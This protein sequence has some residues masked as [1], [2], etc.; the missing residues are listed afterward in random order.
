GDRFRRGPP[1][2]PH[3]PRRGGGVPLHLAGAGAGLLALATAFLDLRGALLLLLVPA[4]L[5]SW[6]IATIR[7]TLMG[8]LD[9]LIDHA[10]G[11]TT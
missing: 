2:R 11:E 5:G 10:I 9:A 1:R 3:R 6:F 4:A 7:K 8:D